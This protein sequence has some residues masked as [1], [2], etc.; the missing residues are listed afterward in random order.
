MRLQSREWERFE[1]KVLAIRNG[2]SKAEKYK[3]AWDVRGGKRWVFC[4]G[5][6]I[7]C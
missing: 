5:S 6:R 2:T 1:E 4:N 7:R 3:D